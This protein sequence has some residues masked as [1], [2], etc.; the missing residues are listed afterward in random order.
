M[1]DQVL[2]IVAVE[3]TA[4]EEPQ[5]SPVA[6]LPVEQSYVAGE[7]IP[8]EGLAGNAAVEDDRT[9]IAGEGARR[10]VGQV[11][12]QEVVRRTCQ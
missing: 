1:V 3:D 6:V 12:R 5:A 8:E 10:T 11:A 2:R 7:D 9:R 4:L